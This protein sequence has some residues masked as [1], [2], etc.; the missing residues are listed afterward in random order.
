M[1]G[2]RTLTTPFA[3]AALALA[4]CGDGERQDAN[5]TAGTST[6]AVTEASFPAEQRL[7][8]QSQMRIAVKN[9]GGEALRDV[10]VTIDSFSRRAE[11]RGL[12]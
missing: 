3:V 7:A 11:Q 12:G 1:T 8:K 6:V 10:A 9:T 4:G 2:H 5:E